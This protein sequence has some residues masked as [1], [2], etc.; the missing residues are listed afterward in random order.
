MASF[1]VFKKCVLTSHFIK[2]TETQKIVWKNVWNHK[3]CHKN[4]QGTCA[5]GDVTHLKRQA[6]FVFDNFRILLM[7]I[8]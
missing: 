5:G 7:K 6:A 1:K 4:A 3:K 8:R 2:I